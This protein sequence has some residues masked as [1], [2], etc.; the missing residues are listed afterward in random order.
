MRRGLEESGQLSSSGALTVILRALRYVGPFKQEFG[1]KILLMVVSLLPLLVMPWP[2]KI[3]IDH[4]IGDAPLGDP[5]LSFPWFMQPFLVAMADASRVELLVGTLLFQ[6][7]LLLLT[8]A[9]GTTG[10]ERDTTNAYLATGWDTATQTE[11][12]ANAGFS[13]TG[14]L[15]GLF[16]FRWT[17]RLTQ[18]INHH[19]RTQLFERIQSLPMTSFDD[20]RIGDAVYRV[21]YDTPAI[22]EVVYRALLTPIGSPLAILLTVAVIGEVYGWGSPIVWAGLSFILVASIPTL[23]FAAALRRRG[24]SSRTAG[25]VTTSTVEEGMSNIL[26]VQSLGGESG[27]RSRFDADSSQSFRQFR[28]L[29][30]V[31]MLATF[32]AGIVGTLVGAKYFFIY[33][34][35]E[36]I[37]GRLTPGDF[38]V[39]LPYCFTIAAACV[40]IGAVWIR[41][42]ERATGLNRVFFLMDL[43]AEEDPPGARPLPRVREKVCVEDVSFDYDE[44]SP[45]LCGASFEARV[46][47]ITAFVGPAGAGKT[48]LAY[49]IPRF[50]GPRSGRVSIDG[51]DLAGVTMESLRSQVAFVFQET[52]LFD[53][54][55]EE[56]IRLAKP[57]ATEAEIRRAARSAGADEFIRQLPQGYATPLGRA[58]GKL[59]VG[60]KQ[61]LSIARALVRDAPILILDEPTSALDPKTEQQ[62][63]AALREASRDRIVIVIAHRLSTIREADQIFFI[64]AG[65]SIE[66][67]THAELMT[68]PDGAYRHFVE[69][70]TRG[71]A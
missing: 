56:N 1:V 21:M 36:V 32:S 42:Q 38:G 39:L 26:A 49:L 28:L 69:L 2:L 47:Q 53:A 16:D 5:S 3:L 66:R 15:L 23:P 60:Q 43:P 4:V 13:L 18:R 51:V 9:F 70:Q 20:E 41:I 67:G 14:G 6:A 57:D 25:A 7:V 29:A 48:T 50:I 63:V 31:A 10:R 27:E 11:N 8:G 45:A 59:S 12:A 44:D 24:G 58:G 30:L 34:A 17:L 64:E 46:G 35:T 55:I 65:R 52:V 54:S 68:Q 19:Y 33:P 22:T 37:H 62:L 71:V 61:R 40:D